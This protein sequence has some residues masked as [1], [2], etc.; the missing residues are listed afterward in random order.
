MTSSEYP[1]RYKNPTTRLLIEYLFPKDVVGRFNAMHKRLFD[2]KYFGR[3]FTLQVSAKDITEL[4]FKR[5]MEAEGGRLE[6]LQNILELNRMDNL[7]VRL[8]DASIL[9]QQK[10]WNFELVRDL[11]SF[12]DAN[13]IVLDEKSKTLSLAVL[14]GTRQSRATL[15]PPKPGSP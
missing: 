10:G 6:I 8:T 13:G 15:W 11:Y 4:E 12:W 14:T 9:E 5:F 7:L 3:Y 1:A 2:S